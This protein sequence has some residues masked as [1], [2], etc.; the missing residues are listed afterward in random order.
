MAKGLSLSKNAIYKAEH[1][2]ALEIQSARVSRQK[3]KNETDLDQQIKIDFSIVL[4]E[5]TSAFDGIVNSFFFL[6]HFYQTVLKTGG[7]AADEC[8]TCHVL[9]SSLSI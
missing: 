3:M 4:E 2:S 9:T 5:K 8:E 7:L 6:I 1:V